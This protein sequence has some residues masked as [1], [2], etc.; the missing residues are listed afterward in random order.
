MT[1]TA[2]LDTKGAGDANTVL[3][4]MDM[5]RFATRAA[6]RHW[7]LGLSICVGTIV[8]GVAYANVVP[9][10]FSVNSRILS[11]ETFNKTE[12]LSSP[13]RAMP[14]LNPFSGSLELLTQRSVLLSI[15][16]E[17]GLVADIESRQS[18]FMREVDGYINKVLRRNVP[19]TDDL[20]NGIARGLTEQIKLSMS[21]D[22]VTI[23]VTWPD[24]RKAVEI[25][26]LL[27]SKFISLL[28][29]RETASISAAISIL[30]DEARRAGEAIEPALAEAV[31]ER[32]QT[33]QP[34]VSKPAVGAVVAAQGRTSTAATEPAT[35]S[36]DAAT[37]Q[38]RQFSAKLAEVNAK[39]Q[40]AETTWHGQQQNLNTRLA[41]LRAVYGP[42]HPQVI[43]QQALIDAAVEPP[44]ELVELQ[45]TR[46]ELLHAI[47][48][49]PGESVASSAQPR[50]GMRGSFVARPVVG[51]VRSSGPTENF[52]V[53]A[54][55]AK[56][57]HAV[58]NYNNV[59]RRLEAARLQ[60]SASQATFGMHFV[61][62]EKPE[63][64]MGPI[65]PLRKLVRI[66]SVA[67]G[68]VLGFLAGTLRELLSGR[69]HD[70][71][72]LKSFGLKDFGELTAFKA[73]N[74]KRREV[75]RP[76]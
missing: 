57:N 69:I 72:Q 23:G 10:K 58:D 63:Y 33:N 74:P 6:R 48:N 39:I 43:Q 9:Q 5:A 14:N 7:R 2:E 25:V 28:R 32:D 37:L 47:Q 4:P 61:V 40:A 44:A 42:A 70:P 18:P 49:A 17:A 22:V 20:R 71:L 34:A 66:A 8:A 73:L 21:R 35:V 15:V 11:D 75:A 60:L 26:Q 19:T 12:A 76:Q 65:K 45:R 1:S 59:Q 3:A 50:T 36:N 55:R 68:L 46:A 64:P 27:D 54:P 30:E 67:A 51:Q 16:D 29:D 41:E 38:A 53:T 13:D 24:A 62:V 52:E 31:R 56:L